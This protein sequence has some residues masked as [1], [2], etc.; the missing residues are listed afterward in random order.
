ML[1]NGVSSKSSPGAEK[2]V[3]A[4]LAQL[5][6]AQ[7]WTQIFHQKKNNVTG[8]EL[9]LNL[10][11]LNVWALGLLTEKVKVISESFPL[12]KPRQSERVTEPSPRFSWKVCH[13]I[14]KTSHILIFSEWLITWTQMFMILAFHKIWTNQGRRDV[15]GWQVYRGAAMQKS[16]SF[17]FLL[18]CLRTLPMSGHLY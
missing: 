5:R 7:H 12:T 11:S 2:S 17:C 15:S 13:F 10:E 6:P 8:L 4:C 3:D 9:T 1:K 16:L 14:L 18:F